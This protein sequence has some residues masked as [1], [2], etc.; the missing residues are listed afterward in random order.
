MGTRT[1]LKFYD[2]GTS[3]N[4]YV[5]KHWD[6]YPSNIVKCIEDSLKYAWELPRFEA[7]E[8]ATAFISANKSN[9]GD[10]RYTHSHQMNADT[11]YRY[12]ITCVDGKLNIDIFKYEYDSDKF[13]K[14]FSGDLDQALSKFSN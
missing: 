11:D 13:F 9:A 4:Y 1:T 2:K 14:I 12:N 5:Y 3:N 8:F 6:G 10:I 7:D